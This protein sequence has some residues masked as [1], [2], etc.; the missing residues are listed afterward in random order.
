MNSNE[1]DKSVVSSAN[2]QEHEVYSTILDTLNSIDSSLPTIPNESIIAIVN[3]IN[4]SIQQVMKPIDYISSFVQKILSDFAS[5]LSSI[6]EQIQIPDFSEEK[7]TNCKFVLKH[8]AST[9]G[10]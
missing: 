3:T 6:V 2:N 8:G 4:N 9:D 5:Q 10:L 7:K 1:N